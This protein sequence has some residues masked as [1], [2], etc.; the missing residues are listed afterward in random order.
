MKLQ[1]S[2]KPRLDGT[3]IVEG[4]DGQVYSFVQ[5]ESGDLTCDVPHVETVSGLLAGGLFYPADPAD[6]E[7][8]VALAATAQPADGDE[9]G[10]DDPEDD[11]AIMTA[12]PIEENTPPSRKRPR[13]AE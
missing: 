8:A 3:V 9:A 6:Y 11:A 4:T 7:A 10:D 13:K 12:L 1:T 2:I 5:D